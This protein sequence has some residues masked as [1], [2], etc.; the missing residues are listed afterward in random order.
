MRGNDLR[1]LA[2][3]GGGVRGLSSFMIPQ[4]L[5]GNV[6]INNLLPGLVCDVGITS[7]E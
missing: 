3:H 2:L 5:M 4:Q 1:L 7:I 6:T